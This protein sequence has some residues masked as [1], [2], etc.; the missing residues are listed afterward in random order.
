VLRERAAP[1]CWPPLAEGP[2]R[3]Q[4][5]QGVTDS[6]QR[7]ERFG[8]AEIVLAVDDFANANGDVRAAG[9]AAGRFHGGLVARTRRSRRFGRSASRG[10]ASAPVGMLRPAG[11][12][13]F[14]P[15]LDAQRFVTLWHRTEAH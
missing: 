12:S 5:G 6:V 7:L 8:P 2:L 15:R 13:S 4:I 10:G 1:R 3:S 9:V 11:S 14:S